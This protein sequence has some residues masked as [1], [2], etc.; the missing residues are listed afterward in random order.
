[1]SITL[2][3]TDEASELL[4]KYSAEEIRQLWESGAFG[5]SPK[6]VKDYLLARLIAGDLE[7]EEE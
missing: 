4:R 5:D 2:T 1:M 6:A 3:T 7:K